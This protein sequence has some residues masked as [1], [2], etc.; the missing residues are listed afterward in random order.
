VQLLDIFVYHP[1]A[2]NSPYDDCELN[3]KNTVLHA[4]VLAAALFVMPAPIAA[5][6]GDA[7]RYDETPFIIT[8][9]VVEIKLT[10]PHSILVFDATDAS[11]KVVRW[12]AEMGGGQ[13]LV[14]Q[15]GW[16]K[17][18]LKVGDKITLNGRK[19][20]SGAPYMNMTEKAQII[21]ADTGKEIFRTPNFG[22]PA[23]PPEAPPKP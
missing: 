8:G 9:T 15:F 18:N 12:Q 2:G 23:T 4:S 20:K 16:T 22:E 10:N 17:E 14:R 13:Q 7:G 3:M 5:H 6:H 19:V 21:M 11:G 1:S